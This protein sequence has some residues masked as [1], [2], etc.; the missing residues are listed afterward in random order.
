MRPEEV[1]VVRA[2][3]RARR[4][5]RE[6][7]LS[8]AH[9]AAIPAA[10]GG[11]KGLALLA[12]D[13]FLFGHWF[14]GEKFQPL[15]VGASIGA[16]RMACAAQPDPVAALDRLADAYT[17]QHYPPK[18]TP[19]DV[20]RECERIV[21]EVLGHAPQLSERL[22]VITSR[23]R[24]LLHD[25][26]SGPRFAAAA[27]ANAAAR[28][29]LA[30]FFER[31]VFSGAPLPW[32]PFD[33]FGLARVALSDANRAQALLASGT[34]PLLAEPVRDI[35]GSA[36]GLYWDGGI[37]DYHVFWPWN[38][39]PG[40]VLYPHFIDSIVPGWLD[41][42][43]PWRRA[44][45][46]RLDNLVLLAPSAAFRSRLPGG[47]LPERQDFYRFGVDHAAR[48]GAWKRAMRECELLAEAFQA[49]TRDPAHWP[50]LP[51]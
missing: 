15:L 12:L 14:K 42:S 6:Q 18:P 27:L 32:D 50:V 9:I 47:R 36:R 16:W 49:F 38:T 30:P 33:G 48:I 20:S 13:R 39:L 11:P 41:K 22:C 43:L 45:G 37:V 4:H 21:L 8:P 10:A 24:G 19:H 34:I 51:L 25:R 7:G 29:H 26:Y 1:L 23:S 5:L 17:A 35:P 44:R 40:L 3:A 28:R 46:V 2:G 31:I